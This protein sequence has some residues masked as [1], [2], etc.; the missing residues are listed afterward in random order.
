MNP[1]NVIAYLSRAFAY[2][3]TKE[4]DNSWEDVR[5]AQKLGYQVP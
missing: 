5:R 1:K 3:I 4:Y 2:S